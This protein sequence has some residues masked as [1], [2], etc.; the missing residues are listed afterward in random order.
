MKTSDAE[1]KVFFLMM[2]GDY[3]GHIACSVE[4]DAKARA[5]DCIIENY[6]QA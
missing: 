3:F 5:H 4:G 1:S 6:K 2:I